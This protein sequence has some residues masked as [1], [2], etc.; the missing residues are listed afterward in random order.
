MGSVNFLTDVNKDVAIEKNVLLDVNKTVTSNVVLTGNLATAEASAD[1]LGQGG[2]GGGGGVRTK[3]P[4]NVDGFTDGQV[5]TANAVIG[6]NPDSDGPIAVTDTDIAGLQRTL[7]SEVLSAEG[8][9]DLAINDIQLEKLAFDQGNN[10]FG[11]SFADW[12]VPGGFDPFPLDDNAGILQDFLDNVVP[13]ADNPLEDVC[14][15]F[16]FSDID[17]D[18]GQDE[19]GAPATV[20]VSFWVEDTAGNQAITTVAFVPGDDGAGFSDLAIIG[21]FAGL[22]DESFAPAPGTVL[23]ASGNNAQIVAIGTEDDAD[24]N[25]V[26]VDFDN[27]DRFQVLLEDDPDVTVGGNPFNS[28]DYFAIDSVID[29][30]PSVDGTDASTEFDWTTCLEEDDEFGLLAEVDTFAQVDENGA[31]AFSESLAALDP[32]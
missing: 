26:S 8:Q 15:T 25:G 4:F 28:A 17:W 9:A 21:S 1:A 7:F 32:A 2:G 3:V 5:V 18:P 31:F 23:A 12:I 14:Y 29:E 16:I 6:P 11:N 22:I 30:N 20:R 19:N 13:D 24:G 27:L 10:T